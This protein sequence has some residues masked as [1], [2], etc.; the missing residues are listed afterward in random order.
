[1]PEAGPDPVIVLDCRN[2]RWDPDADAPPSISAGSL[3]AFRP[4]VRGC[5]EFRYGG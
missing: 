5:V 4:G 2:W 1:M 3:F